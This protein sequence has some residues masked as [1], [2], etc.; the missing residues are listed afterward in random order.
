MTTAISSRQQAETEVI[1]ADR[2]GFV[3]SSL[4]EVIEYAKMYSMSGMAPRSL[5]TPEKIVIVIQTGM[6]AGLSPAASVRSLYVVSGTPAW[7]G[8]AALGLVRNSGLCVEWH[9]PTHTGEGDELSCRVGSLRRG[10]PAPIFHD[11]SIADARRAGI[12]GRNSAV[13]KSYPSRMVYY[14]ALGFHLRDQYPD[15]LLGLA[16]A[17]EVRDYPREALGRAST[18][19]G[20]TGEPP[21][22]GP[23]LAGM[24][25]TEEES[26]AAA[27]DSAAS[28]P[29]VPPPTSTPSGDNPGRQID[30]TPQSPRPHVAEKLTKRWDG[31][32]ARVEAFL[33][34]WER[35]VAGKDGEIH[36]TAWAA[37]WNHIDK[38]SYDD[39]K[40]DKLRTEFPEPTPSG[41]DPTP[42][43]RMF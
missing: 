27:P 41:D 2:G 12:L 9:Q 17:E 15:V 33:A 24:L 10:D 16:I 11:F 13:W 42:D 6:E 40:D 7:K 5:D 31:D 32:A 34:S 1:R 38:G 3:P 35:K 36:R 18:P 30:P 39:W 19:S 26:T 8:D 25:G 22:S 20:D 14:R 43:D 4:S 28:P 21:A 23:I 29:A 37:L